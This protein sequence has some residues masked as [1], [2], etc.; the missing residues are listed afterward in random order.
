MRRSVLVLAIALAVV[1]P[2]RLFAKS[3]PFVSTLSTGSSSSLTLPKELVR[4]VSALLELKHR[5]I[6]DV[7]EIIHDSFR[8]GGTF[9]FNYK[10]RADWKPLTPEE[11]FQNRG[12]DCSDLTYLVLSALKSLP[13]DKIKLGFIEMHFED[14]PRHIWHALPFILARNVPRNL[15]Y[16]PFEN[17]I[18]FRSKTLSMFGVEGDWHMVVVD[19]QG[20]FGVRKSEKVDK[21]EPYPI[22]ALDSY[23]YLEFGTHALF[24]KDDKT[25]I[26]MFKKAVGTY[27][28]F[29]AHLKL[30][31]L[32]PESESLADKLRAVYH[33]RKA[34]SME[35]NN[36]AVRNTL[37]WA[38]I[39]RAAIADYY[40]DYS[41]ALE[42]LLEGDRVSPND[43]IVR[44]QMATVYYNWGVVYYNR[45]EYLP[46][47]SKFE[48]AARLGLKDA[49]D[50]IRKIKRSN[51]S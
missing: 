20:M 40:D 38:L 49:Q 24:K 5:S 36:R 16:L 23:Y 3:S 19:P 10:S 18:D 9:G 29:Y 7:A 48:H 44:S 43:N 34:Y 46:A 37:V 45:G 14:Q 22:D 28:F 39:R 41:T 50:M 15:R 6:L 30:A 51:G 25:A 11:T 47:L 32:L 1:Q 4:Y 13:Q 31:E 12:G 33:A 27:D 26:E 2:N 21:Q 8:I 42:Y 35:P 17:D